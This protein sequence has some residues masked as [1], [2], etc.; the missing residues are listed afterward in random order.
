MSV[1]YILFVVLVSG[2]GGLT[3][4]QMQ[5]FD[6]ASCEKERAKIEAVFSGPVRVHQDVRVK[7]AT[8]MEDSINE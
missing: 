2:S 8:C 3:S 7:Y 1:M 4:E 6:K 5:F